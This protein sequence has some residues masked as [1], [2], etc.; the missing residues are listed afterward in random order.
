MTCEAR[1]SRRI[2]RLERVLHLLEGRLAPAVPDVGMPAGV[3]EAGIAFITECEGC[4]LSPYY[5]S[6]GYLTVGVG[7]LLDGPDD[8]YN[9][10]ITQEESNY[11][12][13]GDVVEVEEC[14][15]A[16]VAVPINQNHYN[17]MASLAF[18]IGVYAFA[19]STL[20]RLLNESDYD[21]AAEQFL[22]WNKITV[23]GEK[24]E[25]EGLNNRRE[26]EKALFE[27]L[28]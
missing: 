8:P 21:G 2:R 28:P 12:L 17:A 25:S 7:H 1:L 10:T 9:R 11:L 19:D 3:D 16:N 27:T 22:V 26:K 20:L 6:A 15:D 23:D 18:N 14:L 4:E 13:E 5:D 24:V